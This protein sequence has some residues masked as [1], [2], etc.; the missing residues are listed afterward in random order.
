MKLVKGKNHLSLKFSNHTIF[1]HDKSN[2]FVAV[3][4]GKGIYKMKRGNFDVKE[5]NVNKIILDE[6]KV[7]KEDS[8]IVIKFYNSNTNALIIKFSN[9]TQ[10]LVMTL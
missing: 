8:D 2:P 7:I 6:Y 5:Q 1:K 9:V 3:G 10:K 4:F